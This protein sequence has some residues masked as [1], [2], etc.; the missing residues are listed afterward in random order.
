M[1][2]VQLSLHEYHYENTNNSS[3]P[4][5]VWLLPLTRLRSLLLLKTTACFIFLCSRRK[6]N[7]FNFLAHILEIIMFQSQA[8]F[9]IATAWQKYLINIYLLYQ[10]SIPRNPVK[11]IN[12]THMWE[13]ASLLNSEDNLRQK[14]T[15]SFCHRILSWDFL[16]SITAW[17]VT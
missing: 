10:T 15:Q 1:I 8:V 17:P 9:Y 4:H 12:A 11:S 3:L 14:T 5:M 13:E 7:R 16:L 6:E 2:H